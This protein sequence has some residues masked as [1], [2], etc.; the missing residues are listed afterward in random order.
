MTPDDRR[1]ALVEAATSGNPKFFLGTDSA[2]HARSAKEAPRCQFVESSEK[3][4]PTE[5]DDESEPRQKGS[6]IGWL[7]SCASV[8]RIDMGSLDS[9]STPTVASKFATRS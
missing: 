6:R 7:V 2:P 3:T 4:V 1:E 5:L 9:D 8:S